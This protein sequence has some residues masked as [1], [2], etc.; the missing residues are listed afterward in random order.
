GLGNFLTNQSASCCAVGAQDGVIVEV[1]LQEVRG[2][3]GDS[4]VIARGVSVTPTRVDRADGHR[5]VDVPVAIAASV[6][7]DEAPDADLV[8]SWY[9]TAERILA[10]ELPEG[11]L[12]VQMGEG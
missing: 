6:A 12:R 10:E 7:A 11:L 3:D 8:A 2:P 1:E 9:R 4:T 5:I